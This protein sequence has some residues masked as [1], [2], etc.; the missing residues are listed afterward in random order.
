[1]LEGG[2]G[3]PSI[4]VVVA[5]SGAGP[6]HKLLQREVRYGDRSEV[7]C[8]APDAVAVPLPFTVPFCVTVTDTVA[9]AVFHDEFE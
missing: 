3:V 9:A 2:I 6:R 1:M 5:V 8:T 7:V 4:I